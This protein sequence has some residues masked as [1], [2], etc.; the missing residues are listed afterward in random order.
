MFNLGSFYEA[1]L[2]IGEFLTGNIDPSELNAATS[3]FVWFKLED[4][5]LGLHS[6]WLCVGYHNNPVHTIELPL[7]NCGH[8]QDLHTYSTFVCKHGVTESEFW[9]VEEV[10]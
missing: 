2:L 6:A 8:C 7:Q 5:D 3:V 9:G 10:F 1:C 4:D